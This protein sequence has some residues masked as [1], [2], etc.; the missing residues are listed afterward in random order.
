MKALRRALRE[1]ASLQL[2]LWNEDAPR[3]SRSIAR[4]TRHRLYPMLPAVAVDDAI[5]L[6]RE[7]SA[8]LRIAA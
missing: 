8:N 5:D 2:D 4:A 3:V 1:I 7:L 6:E